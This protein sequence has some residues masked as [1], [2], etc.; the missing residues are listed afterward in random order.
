MTG[1]LLIHD[2]DLAGRRVDVT[3]EDGVILAVDP[4]TGR[5]PDMGSGTDVIDARGGAVLPGLHDHHIHLLATAAAARSVPA[6]PPTVRDAGQLIAALRRADRLLPG[7]EPIRAIG[8][9]ESVAGPID[10]DWLDALGIARPIRVQ[11][12]TGALW[13]LNTAALF[14]L[15]LGIGADGGGGTTS[16][17]APAAGHPPEHVETDPNGRPTGRLFRADHRLRRAAPDGTGRSGNDPGARRR[18]AER[19]LDDLGTVGRR[20]AS[21]G[22]TGVTDLTPTDD[23][24]SIGLLATA[25]RTGALPI[26]VVVTGNAA[27]P[28]NASSELPRGPV[29][30]VIDDHELPPFDWIT[31]EY[32]RA[33]S[34]GRP[35]AVH[36]VTRDSLVLALA[37]WHDVGAAPGDRI[38]HG[39]VIPV[40]LFADI[41][42]LGLT[43]VTQP[44]FVHERGDQYLTGVEAG[45]VPHLWRCGS[46]LRAGIGVAFG[47]DAPYGSPDPWAMIRSA[48]NRRTERGAELGPAER[49]D[50]TVA[51]D[52]LLGSAATPTVLRR[53]EPGAPADLCVLDRPLADQLADPDAD[54]VAATIVAGATVFHR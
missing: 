28:T 6:G 5:A 19:V 32:T 35:I 53:V 44:S 11:H 25:R 15:G 22:V 26:G 12:R 34:T 30:I 41:R 13:V 42:D 24:G 33:R 10:G 1:R 40:E 39:A 46:L 3:C 2:A 49:I 21:Y 48:V 7:G 54:A 31:A 29:K 9:H 47:S 38:E 37:A 23:P 14:E 8:Y 16:I 27:L 18:D 4:V 51:L 36:S 50:A 52:R 43:V 45:D 17:G 20:L